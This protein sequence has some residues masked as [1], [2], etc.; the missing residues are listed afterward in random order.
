[1]KTKIIAVFVCILLINIFGTVTAFPEKENIDVELNQIEHDYDIA[2][3]TFG[4]DNGC[5]WRFNWHR[6]SN[7][8]NSL[9]RPFIRAIATYGPGDNTGFDGAAYRSACSMDL[10][11]GG[12]CGS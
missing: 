2:L 3:S 1:M 7:N 8:H 11:Q 10:L 12:L 4:S 5:F 6:G 9:S